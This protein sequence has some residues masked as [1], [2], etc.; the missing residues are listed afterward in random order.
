[1][2]LCFIFY[3]QKGNKKS[4]GRTPVRNPIINSLGVCAF[5]SSLD[6]ATKPFIS[7]RIAIV[8]KLLVW[9]WMLNPIAKTVK[10]LIATIW[11][12][13][14]ILKNNNIKATTV[15]TNPA[16]KK[17][18]NSGKCSIVMLFWIK[19]VVKKHKINNG[20][21]RC[22]SFPIIIES[23]FPAIRSIK[24]EIIGS[25]MVIITIWKTAKYFSGFV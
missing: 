24:N 9:L 13:A 2:E 18:Y 20:I 19:I 14:F 4:G 16:K 1:M 15:Q 17:K 5:I 23:T 11:R 12:L 7:T 25:T 21:L 10:A 6:E 3:S 22:D 8:F